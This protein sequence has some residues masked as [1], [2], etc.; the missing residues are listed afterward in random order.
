MSRD[1]SFVSAF[2]LGALTMYFLDPVQGRRRRALAND[3]LTRLSNQLRR[4]RETGYAGASD[5]ANR[6]R[7]TVHEL[8]SHLHPSEQLDDE[9]MNARVRAR[10]GRFVSHPKAIETRVKNGVVQLSGPILAAEVEPLLSAVSR[11]QGVT[12]IQNLLEVHET[13]GNV[14]ALQGSPREH[15]AMLAAS[16]AVRVAEAI[17]GVVLGV[18]ALRTENRTARSALTYSALALIAAAMML[19]REQREELVEAFVS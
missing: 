14:P 15:P 11:M 9:R 18:Q 3:Q 1:T 8:R 12:D 16:P 2:A 10:L 19:S 7:G 6:S 17:T 4:L 13:P 5:I